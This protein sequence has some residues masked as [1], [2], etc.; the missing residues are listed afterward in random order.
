MRILSYVV[1]FSNMVIKMKKI[2]ISTTE[3]YYCKMITNDSLFDIEFYISATEGA[4]TTPEKDD[5]S[6]FCNGRAQLG[7]KIGINVIPPQ[8]TDLKVDIL[9]S[10]ICY[11]KQ[12][13]NPG[14]SP[15][16]NDLL[17]ITDTQTYQSYPGQYKKDFGEWNFTHNN[18]V[19]ISVDTDCEPGSKSEVEIMAWAKI[20][21]YSA[22][23]PSFSKEFY[24]CSNMDEVVNISCVNF[25]FFCDYYYTLSVIGKP[26]IKTRVDNAV[27]KNADGMFDNLKAVQLTCFYNPEIIP[28][29]SDKFIFADSRLDNSTTTDAQY[30]PTCLSGSPCRQVYFRG[31]KGGINTLNRNLVH[32]DPTNPD[33]GQYKSYG[34]IIQVLANGSVSYHYEAVDLRTAVNG[35][36]TSSAA[37]VMT[38]W[39]IKDNK[40][41][42]SCTEHGDIN[43][44]FTIHASDIYGGYTK[45]VIKSYSQGE[46]TLYNTVVVYD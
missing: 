37:M 12:W 6:L 41:E 19:Y 28:G 43:S 18:L 11:N 8:N 24:I 16:Q 45:T 34:N 31:D 32:C 9:E 4:S 5:A 17:G 27:I 29:L 1:N 23:T 42:N 22:S 25:H 7:I 26:S 33:A 35:E 38:S 3:R 30:L 15:E 10:G 39:G 20:K 40:I 21:V 36:Y 14:L 13:T 46:F 44:Y 2:S